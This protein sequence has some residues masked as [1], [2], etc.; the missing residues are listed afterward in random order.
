MCAFMWNELVAH[1]GANDVVSCLSH[2]IYNTVT[3]EPNGA[4][5]GPTTVL[6]RIKAIVLFGSFKI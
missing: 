4:F 2:F 6:A 1:H 3:Q 5:G